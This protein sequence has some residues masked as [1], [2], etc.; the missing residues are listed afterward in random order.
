MKGLL[1]KLTSFIRRFMPSS[2]QAAPTLQGPICS[3]TE[4]ALRDSYLSA[5]R[6]RLALEQ[7]I[8]QE[9]AR[10]LIRR[11]DDIPEPVIAMEDAL[12]S[13][14]KEW[15]E[16]FLDL[17][18]KQLAHHYYSLKSS[19]FPDLKIMVINKGYYKIIFGD[20]LSFYYESVTDQWVMA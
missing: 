7:S 20:R 10:S 12:N 18:A 16:Y 2:T 6:A 15:L 3:S 17:P 4:R 5:V 8:F 9:S 14:P 19:V 13:R 1:T 11:R